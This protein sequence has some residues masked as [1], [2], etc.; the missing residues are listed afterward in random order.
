MWFGS[1]YIGLQQVL[2]S[3]Q[4][5]FYLI[6]GT[7]IILTYINAKKSLLNPV[8]AEYQ[9]HVI[10]KLKDLSEDLFSEFD[11]GSPNYWVGEHHNKEL[12]EFSNE[13]LRSKK[14]QI[15]ATGTWT[16]EG[17]RTSDIYWDCYN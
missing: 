1:L 16:G 3:V 8:H 9:K 10:N 7:V 14:D 12:V 5:R 6:T 11:P 15:L 17:L 2:S 4:I 13:I